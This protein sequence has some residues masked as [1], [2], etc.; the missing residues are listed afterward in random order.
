MKQSELKSNRS[1]LATVPKDGGAQMVI[2]AVPEQLSNA[3]A[4]SILELLFP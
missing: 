1:L 2:E 4:G 3:L